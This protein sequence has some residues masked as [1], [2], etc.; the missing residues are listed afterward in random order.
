MNKIKY[1]KDTTTLWFLKYSWHMY[2]YNE[3]N[4]V[5]WRLKKMCISKDD[6][7]KQGDKLCEYNFNCYNTLWCS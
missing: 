4:N 2:Y 6:S 1:L 7:S 3:I 5:I